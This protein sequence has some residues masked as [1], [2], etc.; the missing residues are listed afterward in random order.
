[1]CTQCVLGPANICML[2]HAP[3]RRCPAGNLLRA[4]VH[5]SQCA[6]QRKWKGHHVCNVPA[7]GGCMQE[8]D[9]EDVRVERELERQQRLQQ[10]AAKQA[11][12]QAQVLS[13]CPCWK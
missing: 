8:W 2:Y 10:E 13:A 1:M 6:V 5:L 11:A 12:L 7:V 3:I 4:T 9:V